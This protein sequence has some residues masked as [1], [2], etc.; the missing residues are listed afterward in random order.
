MRE[1]PQVIAALRAFDTHTLCFQIGASTFTHD[2]V[3][4]AYDA[5]LRERNAWRD[6]ADRLERQQSH[7]KQALRR[8]QAEREALSQQSADRLQ[9]LLAD[10]PNTPT[11]D[12]VCTTS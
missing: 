7:L 4:S 12:A 9:A 5:L 6:H 2:E 11:E 10:L 8:L 3:L 1:D